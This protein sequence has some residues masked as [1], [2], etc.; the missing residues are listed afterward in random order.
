VASVK[1]LNSPLQSVSE[2]YGGQC[3][4]GQGR[5]ETLDPNIS[6]KDP[7]FRSAVGRV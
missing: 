3:S 1:T 5:S 7:R 6:F 2:A 4:D